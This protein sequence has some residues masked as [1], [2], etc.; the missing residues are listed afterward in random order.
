MQGLPRGAAAPIVPDPDYP[1]LTAQENLNNGRQRERERER[2][3]T[4]EV[5][6]SRPKELA[7][8]HDSACDTKSSLSFGHQAGRKS[9]PCHS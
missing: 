4:E 5:D 1:N 8:R 9:N 6:V 2:E 7:L 3:R